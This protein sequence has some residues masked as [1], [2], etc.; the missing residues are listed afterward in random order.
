MHTLTLVT[1]ANWAAVA[2]LGSLRGGA[3]PSCWLALWPMATNFFA[4]IYFKTE[5][6]LKKKTETMGKCMEAKR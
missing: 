2:W 6:C 1:W 5:T 3:R 4:P